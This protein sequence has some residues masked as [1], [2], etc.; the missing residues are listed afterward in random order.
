[1]T[2]QLDRLDRRLMEELQLNARLTVAE[3][4]ERVALSPSACWRR[5]KLLEEAGYIEA[6]AAQLSASRLGYGVRA[7]VSLMMDSHDKETTRAFEARLAEI[8]QILACHNVSGRYD[9]LV[10]VVALDLQD[11]G[12]F[13][14][15]VL[16]MLPG[17]KEIHSS[18]SLKAVKS[19][20]RLPLP[21]RAPPGSAG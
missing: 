7:F 19:T 17:V 21:D 2:D 10:E 15:D 3:L 11:F 5:V 12:E 1:M 13:T 9:F 20:R 18:F 14:R 16:Q 4:S 6:Y 8:P